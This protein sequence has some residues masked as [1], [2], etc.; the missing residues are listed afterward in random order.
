MLI[1]YQEALKIIQTSIRPLTQ[2][3][4]LPLLKALH[5][6]ASNAVHAKFA[7]PATPMSLKEGY[8]LKHDL[9]TM[10]YPLSHPTLHA[11][12]PMAVRLSTGDQIP[13]D[14]QAV[15]P[16][17]DVRLDPK[18]GV[19]TLNEIPLKGQHIKQ[20]G[21]DIAKG[22]VLLHPFEK[23]GAYKITALSSQGIQRVRV[24]KKPSVS[25]LS[26]GDALA[27]GEIANSNA[28]SLAARIVEQGGKIHA[29]LTCKEHTQT[30]LHHLQTLAP[31]S[32]ILITTGA[33]SRNDAMRM[34]LNHHVL[35]TL[36]DQVRL[37][38]AKPS[39]LSLFEGKPILHLPGLPLAC[40]LGFEMLGTP[41]LR[42]LLHAACILPDFMTCINQK[43]FTCKKNCMNAIPGYS[44]GKSFVHAPY[45][46]A[47]RLN[48][49]SRCNGYTLIEDKEVIE[50]GEEIAFFYF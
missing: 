37:S 46:E 16:E 21:E 42:H 44:D 14:V 33:L 30:I 22:E 13:L 28:M 40:M 7:L 5:R 2:T 47:G 11:A 48:I 32:D 38:P 24:I 27:E 17:E 36:F 23:I 29:I 9:G 43:K 31:H 10:T 26:I 18:T 6:I 35:Q 50:E 19:I 39:A 1:S 41:L 49:L 25:I 8:G 15:I 12:T 3:Q 34:I 20:K 45:Y 4:T